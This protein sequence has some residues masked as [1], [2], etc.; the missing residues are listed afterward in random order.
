MEKKDLER[1]KVKERKKICFKN[2]HIAKERW[3]LFF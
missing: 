2:K 1:V 3:K